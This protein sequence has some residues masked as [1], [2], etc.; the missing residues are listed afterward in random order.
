MVM[1]LSVV[2]AW[3]LALVHS[4]QSVQAD[5][6]TEGGRVNCLFFQQGGWHRCLEDGNGVGKC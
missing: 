6:D 4:L 3:A 5:R 1:A 2:F